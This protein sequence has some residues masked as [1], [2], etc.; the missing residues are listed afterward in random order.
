MAKKQDDRPRQRVYPTGTHYIPGVAAVERIVPA[1]VADRLVDGPNAAFTRA[2][3]GP[4]G[5]PET[6]D[7]REDIDDVLENFPEPP[8]EV[9]EPQ[10]A[11]VH[12][13]GPG[14]NILTGEKSDG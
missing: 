11:P 6:P 12:E 2:K 7:V 4:E 10:S 14:G 13:T 9:E 8:T 1:E 5:A 3:P